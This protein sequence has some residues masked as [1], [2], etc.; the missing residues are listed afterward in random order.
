MLLSKA[1]I[2]SP[3]FSLKL[4][5]PNFLSMSR[6]FVWGMSPPPAFTLKSE[7]SSIFVFSLVMILAM[8]DMSFTLCFSSERISFRS[9]MSSIECCI[10]GNALTYETRSGS[11][12]CRTD[13]AGILRVA[14]PHLKL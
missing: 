9:R 8:S 1:S 6:G 4:F 14:S 10:P 12:M 13:E 3:G 2:F 11:N 5:P 7:S